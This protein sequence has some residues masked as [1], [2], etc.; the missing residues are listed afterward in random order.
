MAV[1]PET[2]GWGRTSYVAGM[3]GKSPLV[4]SRSEPLREAWRETHEHAVR[5]TLSIRSRRLLLAALVA[6]SSGTYVYFYARANP[7]FVSDFDQVWAG[8]AAVLRG[9]NPYLV[10]G[11]R[12]AFHWAWPLYYPMPA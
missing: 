2:H 9:E 5:L 3:A 7:D 12:R 10:V 1:D 4:H 6:V 8:A 11:P